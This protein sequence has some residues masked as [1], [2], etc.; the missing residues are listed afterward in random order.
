MG[1]GE[2]II[3]RDVTGMKQKT[4]NVKYI[5]LLYCLWLWS[6][7]G[8]TTNKR[9]ARAEMEKLLGGKQQRQIKQIQSTKMEN[10]HGT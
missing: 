10:I 6:F 8:M 7:M 9:H 3:R 1:E 4:P 5:L 2:I